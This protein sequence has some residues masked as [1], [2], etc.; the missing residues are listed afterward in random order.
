MFLNT[1]KEYFEN[2]KNNESNK[3]HEIITLISYLHENNKELSNMYKDKEIVF[4]CDR[5]YHSME[6]FELC[7]MYNFKY[8][9]RVRDN[10]KIFSDDL[11]TKQNT[12]Y[13]NNPAVRKI[14]DMFILNDTVQLDGDLDID[15]Q[16]PIE[17][18][19]ISNL[20]IE[21][22]SDKEI[23]NIYSARWNIEVFFKHSKE[24]TKLAI[25]KTKNDDSYEKQKYFNFMITYISKIINYLY[26]AKKYKNNEQKI[27]NENESITTNHSNIVNGV[28]SKL[29]DKLCYGTLNDKIMDHF[30]E[31]Y[32]S[33][34]ISKKNRSFPRV[35]LIPGSKWYLKKYSNDAAQKKIY[36]AILSGTIN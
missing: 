10:C 27:L 23:R 24:K 1:N 14:T 5:A 7:E 28:Y 18:N 36:K 21:L 19:L 16:I 26:F 35:G 9:I 30:M 3:N 31:S 22:F 33:I 25:T 6:F 17:C 15:V 29:I 20:S 2:N 32:I 12:K 11:T 4:V 8:I 13:R 34:N